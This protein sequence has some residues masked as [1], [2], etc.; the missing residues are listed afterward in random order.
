MR[1][2][3]L[4]SIV[5][6]SCARVL[7][8]SS[9]AARRLSSFVL[10]SSS[11]DSSETAPSA[12]YR[13]SDADCLVAHPQHWKHANWRTDPLKLRTAA[14]A[15]SSESLNSSFWGSGSGH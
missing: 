4:S 9:S 8:L 14:A 5:S 6:A 11:C 3:A 7:S 15:T 10:R 2:F 1:R 13:L 12:S